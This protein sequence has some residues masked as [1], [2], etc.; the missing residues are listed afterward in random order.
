MKSRLPGGRAG[1]D[2][3]AMRYYPRFMQRARKGAYLLLKPLE[4]AAFTPIQI[5]RR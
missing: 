2:A 4:N 1:Q 3:G 5:N